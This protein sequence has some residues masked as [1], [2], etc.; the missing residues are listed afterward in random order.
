MSQT[1]LA[2]D[3]AFDLAAGLVEPA[4]PAQA[5]QQVGQVAAGCAF[6]RRILQ[7]DIAL[8]GLTAVGDGLFRTV[9]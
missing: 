7:P 1:R 2:G 8:G 5:A 3:G 4:Q 9:E 6:V